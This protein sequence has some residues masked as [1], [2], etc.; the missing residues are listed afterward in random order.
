MKI[1][2]V[3]PAYNVE[4]YIQRSIN[5]VLNQTYKAFEVLVVDDGSTDN[6]AKLIQAYG[7]KV[8]YLYKENG[9]A[10]SARNLGIIKAQGDWIAFL[11]S[12]D[13]WIETH[14]ENFVQTVARKKD[15]MWYGAPV[16]HVDQETGRMLFDYNGKF[17]KEFINRPYFNDYLS[18]LPPLGFF[19]TPTMIIKKEIFHKVQFF[20]INKKNGQD[21]NMWLRIGLH[22]PTI[23]Y[24]GQ[25]GAIVYKRRNS[26][27]RNKKF[28]TDDFIERYLDYEDMIRSLGEDYLKRATPRLQDWII[29]KLKECILMNDYQSIVKLKD[30]LGHYFPFRY[31]IIVNTLLRFTFLFKVVPIK[32]KSK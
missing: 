26:I 8:T 7:S 1:T 5:S 15:L 29:R 18:A 22:Y 4:K 31:K 28:S 11:D 27:S 19:S 2:A 23:G 6:T 14:L 12:D 21:R 25:T 30:T 32:N 17:R 3:I 9:G 20:D 10:S 16:K 24:T 13:E